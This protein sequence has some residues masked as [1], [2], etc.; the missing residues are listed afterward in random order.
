M[1]GLPVVLITIIKG[2]TGVNGEHCV[3]YAL[4]SIAK[5]EEYLIVSTL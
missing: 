3:N 1:H 4:P 2:Y 5:P